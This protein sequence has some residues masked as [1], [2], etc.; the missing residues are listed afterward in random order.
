MSI[1]TIVTMAYGS[2]YR[3]RRR[4]GVRTSCYGGTC[5]PYLDTITPVPYSRKRKYVPPGTTTASGAP[6]RT[7]RRVRPRTAGRTATRTKQKTLRGKTTKIGENSSMSVNGMGPR[8][9]P[10]KYGML[11]QK[12]ISPQ[13]VAST[14][15][16]YVASSQGRQNFVQIPFLDKSEL[17][18]IKTSI[19]AGNRSV[20]FMLKTGRLRFSFRN[21]TNTNARCAIYDI[22]CKRTGYSASLDEPL[23]AWS[24]GLTDYGVGGGGVYTCNLTPFKSPE[25]RKLYHVHKVTYVNLEPGQQHEH[26]VHH[27]YQKFVET[28]DIDNAPGVTISGITRYTLLVFF[29]HLSHQH[30]DPA[31]VTVSPV[32]IDYS[33]FKEYSY[34]WIEKSVPSFAVTD[35]LP[36]SILDL[37]Q[38]GESGDVDADVTAA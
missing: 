16:N 29:G 28:T 2:N 13:T 24:K 19:S 8:Y 37:D 32:S 21:Q 30:D 14:T 25:F 38:M 36:T 31:Q 6:V 33:I 3:N 26:I 4:L 22:A 35:A 7:G 27:R 11:A 34:G 1:L 12:I 17:A 23:E 10:A 9:M 5:R 18:T 20:S 15:S